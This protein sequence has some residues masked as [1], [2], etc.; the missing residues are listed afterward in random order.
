MHLNGFEI[1]RPSQRPVSGQLG[2]LCC[3]LV[4]AGTAQGQATPPVS[5]SI[6]NPGHESERA[7]PV[8]VRT[9]SDLLTPRL[10]EAPATAVS[11]N[12]THVAA[13]LTARIE[14]M[15]VR[16]GDELKPGALI[17]KLDCSDFTLAEHRVKAGIA[18][19][20]AQKR[21]AQQQ[22][23]RAVK[24]VKQKSASQELADQRRA[25]LDRLNAEIDGQEVALKE[26]NTR[27]SRCKIHAPY[28][29]LV[30]ER[31]AGEG[32]IAQPGT[33]LLR[34]L[35]TANV[36]V[37]A[38]IRQSEASSLLDAESIHFDSNGHSVPVSLRVLSPAVDTRS[39]SREARLEFHKERVLPGASGRLVWTA[40]GFFLPAQYVLERGDKLG[41]FIVQKDA[42]G[43]TIAQ[44]VVLPD[45]L[46]GRPALIDL[47]MAER[48]DEVQIIDQ[49]R[50]GL[51]DGDP[52]RIWQNSPAP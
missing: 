5:E 1:L 45:A 16:V 15:P 28:Q 20:K 10:Y 6:G 13:E 12:E 49:G 17:L 35:D 27:A 26:A 25:E 19:L 38:Q 21:L 33:P 32:E 52:V 9:A 31:M 51:R 18:A 24:L 22:L 14:S 7:V 29:A 37:S 2:I 23:R 40:S 30:M 39:R 34:I 48:A 43:Q 8:T 11:R 3:L 50:Y 42:S 41:S 46:E 36:E 47:K 4:L 44:F